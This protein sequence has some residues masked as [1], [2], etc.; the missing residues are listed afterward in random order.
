MKQ[1]LASVLVN[2]TVCA[3]SLTGYN[4]WLA[5]QIHEPAPAF[6]SIADMYASGKTP[7]L[8]EDGDIVWEP[9]WVDPGILCTMDEC[10][11]FEDDA[12]GELE[13]EGVL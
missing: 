3:V 4:L 9:T 5:H 10:C 6:D 2:F 12:I 13:C 1:L 8:E 7:R 11:R